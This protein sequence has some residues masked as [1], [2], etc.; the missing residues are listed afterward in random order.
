[1]L[2]TRSIKRRIKTT[3]S[4]R[5]ITKAMEMVSA[6]KMRRA[7]LS[8]LRS[9]P[10]AKKLQEILRRLAIH[11]DLT[12][13]PLFA[14]NRKGKTVIVLVSSDRGLTGGLATTLFRGLEDFLSQLK[15]TDDQLDF[16]VVGKKSR[17]YLKKTAYS[18]LADFSDLPDRLTFEETLP[19]SKL[20]VDGYQERRF[21]KIYLIHMDFVSTLIQRVSINQLLPILL[22]TLSLPATPQ[23]MIELDVTARYEYIFEPNPQ[24]LLAGLVPYYLE[25]QVYQIL[26]DARASEHSARMV[27]MKNASDNASDII[28]DL[29]LE[30]NKSR[31]AA[32]TNELLDI[33]TATATSKS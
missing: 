14:V 21:K 27:A 5:Q 2:G 10:Y 1:M 9:K 20:L 19:L 4:I 18:V 26:L 25:I 3:Q 32:I 7:Q 23:E 16:I 24:E 15:L 29:T 28:Y 12:Q 13:L 22:E 8:A 17:D 33:V 31:Q 6:S 30:Y 11:T